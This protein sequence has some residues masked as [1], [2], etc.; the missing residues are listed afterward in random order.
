[1]AVAMMPVGLDNHA[2]RKQSKR[3]G[4]R[5]IAAAAVA[6]VRFGRGKR[7]DCDCGGQDRQDGGA[8]GFHDAFSP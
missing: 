4:S 7:R 5:D 1:M 6:F 3:N 8:D 2:C